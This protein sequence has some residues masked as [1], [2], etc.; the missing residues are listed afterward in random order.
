MSPSE[1]TMDWVENFV[2]KHALCPFAAQPFH[3]GRVGAVEIN[4][5]DEERAFYAALT[6]V[7]ALLDEKPGKLETTLLVF[8]GG[9]LANFETFLDFVYTLEETFAETGADELVQL[10]HFHPNYHF[11]GVAEDDPGNRTNRAPFP[12]VQLLRT[13]SVAAA[14]ANYPEIESIPE[15]NVAR[16]REVFGT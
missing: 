4:S 3:E 15:R 12:V 2:I 9:P 16:M 8:T 1:T 7:Q 13:G 14:V 11:E 5:V 10:A 6:Q